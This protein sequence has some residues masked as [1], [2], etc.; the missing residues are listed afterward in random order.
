M[1]E[2][3]SERIKYF[4]GEVEI[5]EIAEKMAYNSKVRIEEL[6]GSLALR[7]NKWEETPHPLRS[8]FTDP[9]G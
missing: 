8:P 2:R 6:F 1:E 9:S 5:K 7:E 3:E 4:P